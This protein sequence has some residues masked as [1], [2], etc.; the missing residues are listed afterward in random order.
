MGAGT[1]TL[2]TAYL[3]PGETSLKDDLDAE[4]Q[5]LTPAQAD[6]SGARPALLGQI[7]WPLG[8]AGDSSVSVFGSTFFDPDA[9]RAQASAT[10][11]LTTSDQEVSLTAGGQ[12]GPEPLVLTFGL[13][14][15]QFS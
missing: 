5:R 7:M 4:P 1:W 8:D 6:P 2:E 13:G 9:V 14:V 3:P 11:T 10:Y 12:F 15:K